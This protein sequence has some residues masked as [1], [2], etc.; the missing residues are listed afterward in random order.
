MA[1]VVDTDATEFGGSGVGN[2]GQVDADGESWHGQ[3]FSA[4]LALPPLG[5]IWL[6]PT[7]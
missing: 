7:S 6:V 1:G 4:E 3:P 5:V 2:A